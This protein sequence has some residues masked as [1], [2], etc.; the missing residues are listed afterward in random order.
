MTRKPQPEKNENDNNLVGVKAPRISTNQQT[1][2]S[3]EV[4]I[5]TEIND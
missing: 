4:K 2:T 3:A 1:A 5:K